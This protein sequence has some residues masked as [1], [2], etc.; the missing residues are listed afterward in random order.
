MTTLTEFKEKYGEYVLSLKEFAHDKNG[1][2]YDVYETLNSH[3]FFNF[4][5]RVRIIIKDDKVL[6]TFLPMSRISGDFK[7]E[8]VE[9]VE[10]YSKLYQLFLKHKN[11]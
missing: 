5:G 6:Q 9:N 8:Y 11:K 7:L 1:N 10:N 4:L 3:L 2:I